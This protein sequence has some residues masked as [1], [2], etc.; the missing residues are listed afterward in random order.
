MQ[1]YH[2]AEEMG[3]ALSTVQ[4]CNAALLPLLSVRKLFTL[5]VFKAVIRRDRSPVY[6]KNKVMGNG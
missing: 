2:L 4:Y 3:A 1:S 6:E 5:E